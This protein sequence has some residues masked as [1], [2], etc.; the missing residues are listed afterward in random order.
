MIMHRID[1]DNCRGAGRCGTLPTAQGRQR[2]V[3]AD[4]GTGVDQDRPLAGV[5]VA[6]IRHVAIESASVVA[7]A[8]T[9]ESGESVT[10]AQVEE[11]GD[12]LSA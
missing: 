3:R 11:E 2:H 12:V 7:E 6:S 5:P 1:A 4:P 8:R 10:P 9:E